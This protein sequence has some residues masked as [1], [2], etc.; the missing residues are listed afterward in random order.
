MLKRHSDINSACS[1]LS[2]PLILLYP[3]TLLHTD[4]EFLPTLTV[5]DSGLCQETCTS[6]PCLK[7]TSN[8]VTTQQLAHRATDD[9]PSFHL[10]GSKG[11]PAHPQL[12]SSYPSTIPQT[13]S[14]AKAIRCNL[15]GMGQHSKEQVSEM[16][17]VDGRSLLSNIPHT[18][19]TTLYIH[20]LKSPV[21]FLPGFNLNILPATQIPLAPTRERG[22]LPLQASGWG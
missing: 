16:T 4:S 18:T 5:S 13:F 22:S 17:R 1:T 12:H 6:L 7:A 10:A 8:L 2:F 14:Q 21:A 11:L 9:R 15:Q 3:V 19:H 20:S